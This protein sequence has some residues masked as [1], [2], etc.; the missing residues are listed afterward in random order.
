MK[1]AES[2]DIGMGVMNQAAGSPSTV[3]I[4]RQFRAEM[5][6]GSPGPK[7]NEPKYGRVLPFEFRVLEVCLESACRCLES[8][9]FDFT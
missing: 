9:V 4:P 8:E 3:D 2:S 5:K 1:A 6:D 7:L